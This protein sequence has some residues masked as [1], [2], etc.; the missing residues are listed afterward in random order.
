MQTVVNVNVGHSCFKYALLSIM[1]YDCQRALKYEQRLDDL[2]SG[3]VDPSD[4]CIKS[5]VLK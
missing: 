3:D 2:D 1:H 5:D 4:I